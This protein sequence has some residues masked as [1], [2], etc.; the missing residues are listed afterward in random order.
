MMMLVSCHPL[1]PYR[2][3]LARSGRIEAADLD[4]W[5]GRYVTLVGWWV[6]GKVVQTHK[7][8]PMEF[9]TFEDTTAIFDTTFFPNAYNRFCRKLSRQR[10]Y[11]LKG[12]VDEEFGVATL[13]V[14][15]VGFLDGESAVSD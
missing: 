5:V 11:V 4:N 7:G 13:N 1:V 6:T 12:R 10:P 9:I 8:Q 2:R 15:W 3:Q 14:E